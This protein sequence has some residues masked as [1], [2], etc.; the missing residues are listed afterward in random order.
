MFSR[1]N[2]PSSRSLTNGHIT[3]D[4]FED[5]GP[6]II[7][8]KLNDHS[9]NLFAVIPDTVIETP[10]G[11]YH[12]W[13]GHRIWHA[14]EGMPRSYL[15]DD[16][17]V[18]VEETPRGVRLIQPVEA[19]TGI[20]KTMEIELSPGKAEVILHHTLKNESLWTLTYAP[21][22]I[23]Q[24]NLG[25]LA[26]FPQPTGPSDPGGLLPNRQLVLWPYSHLSDP[27]FIATDDYLFVRGEVSDNP[28]KMGTFNRHGWMG[29]LNQ[30]V[31]FV[32]HFVPDST[33]EHPDK[34]CNT[35]C[36]VWNQFIELESLGALKEVDPGE[37]VEHVEIW[38][39]HSAENVPVTPEGLRAYVEIMDL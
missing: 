32:K 11:N 37:S 33:R 5:A 1:N 15:P 22:G 30:G 17:G 2:L 19:A 8:L 10:I 35:E 34:N 21:W 13:G 36:Y 14:P 16:E 9:E 26:I 29:Y 25:G 39:L 23:T 20:Q 4:F 31:F 24:L 28:F 27:R 6:R 7:S 38:E 3:L 18:R 12:I